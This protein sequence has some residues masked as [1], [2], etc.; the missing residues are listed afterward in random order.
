L[1]ASEI[2]TT[3]ALVWS[4]HTPALIAIGFAFH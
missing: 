2:R 1:P 3:T 4:I